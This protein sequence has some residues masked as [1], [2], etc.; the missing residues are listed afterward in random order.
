MSHPVFLACY[1]RLL[2]NPDSAVKLAG[3]EVDNG[4]VANPALPPTTPTTPRTREA[5]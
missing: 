5:E 4:G 2:R 1:P 3:A